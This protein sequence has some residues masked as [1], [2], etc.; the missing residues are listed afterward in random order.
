MRAHGERQSTI[1]RPGIPP[2]R[3]ARG[4]LLLWKAA[5]GL[6][7]LLTPAPATPQLP[8]Q[9]SDSTVV[10]IPGI[11][12]GMSGFGRIFWGNHYRAAWTTPIEVPILNLHTFGQGLTPVRRGGGQ[13]T[14]SLRFEGADGREY[15]FRSM[16][17]NPAAALPPILRT[18]V[19]ADILQDQISSQH[20][21]GALVCEPLL[22]AAGV[23]QAKPRLAV[24]PDDPIL[25]EFRDEFSGML[26]IIEERPDE[27][28]SALAT[29]AG[30]LQVIGSES[31]FERLRRSPEDRVNSR[32]F[33][34][35][36]LLDFFL[37]D[38]DRHADQWRWARFG[39]D[40]TPG[41][42]PVPRDR[43]QAF[44]KLDGVFPTI[45][46]WILPQIVGFSH[47][48]LSTYSLHWNARRLDRQFLTNLE[49]PVWDSIATSVASKL[50]DEV[51]EEAVRRLPDEMYEADGQ[52]LE[53]ALKRRRTDLPKVASS[54]YRLVAAQV[55]VHA[56]DV[57]EEVNVRQLP[58]GL[59]EVTVAE[60]SANAAPYYRR[61]F[62]PSETEDIRILLYDGHDRVTFSGGDR[63]RP[64]VRVV[65]GEGND[66]FVFETPSSGVKLYDTRGTNRVVASRM[67]I[68]EKPHEPGESAAP[69]YWGSQALPRAKLWFSSDY[70]LL[71]GGGF[72]RH[73]YAFRKDPYA[74]E[75]KLNAALSTDGRYDLSIEYDTRAE[76]SPLHAGF[77][78]YATSLDIVHYYGIGND[79]PELGNREYHKVWRGLFVIEPVVASS[80][81]RVWDL[82]LGPTLRYSRTWE[83]T[84]RFIST[85]PDLY[86]AGGFGQV[87]LVFNLKLDTR[88]GM[89]FDEIEELEGLVGLSFDVAGSVYPE[90][91][92]LDGSYGAVRAHGKTYLPAKLLPHT[93]LA[94]RVGAEKIWGSYPWFDAAF[95]GGLQS[96]RG[97][98]SQRFAGDASLF[99]SAELRTH[100]TQFRTVIPHLFGVSGSA[101][102]GRVWVDGQSPGGW[103]VGLGGG[104]WLGF[105]GSRYLFSASY[106]K[107]MKEQVSG[108]YIDWG[109]AF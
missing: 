102:A 66:T 73:A 49:K 96:L 34:N 72:S 45:G 16:D 82:A 61:R 35:A 20:P 87:G 47:K 62:D 7:T 6:F 101:D 104:I 18:T 94:L 22:E 13:Q 85:L 36:R 83:N 50:T 52:W 79:I 65:G 60:Q 14:R 105:F 109:F 51:I 38:W 68:N 42:Y 70:G 31:L 40:S 43:D 93:V 57:D 77:R 95:I 39:P 75:W 21:V 46:Q 8:S 44:S 67:R 74:T 98:R 58:G 27:G 107:G 97:W 90:F 59:L 32:A 1:Q 53:N 76:N 86:G 41:W 78:A 30:A 5:V 81:G 89:T 91:W 28:A 15:S 4:Q 11:R 106:F 56:T 64:T 10:V 12:Y 33:L 63:L 92:D 88:Q 2:I 55:D 25:G 24:M 9:T 100:I 37:G 108:L 71:I 29:F 17:K 80:P 19:A 3:R 26:G 99:G 54:F 103:H 69:Q 84:G 48:Y 23:L